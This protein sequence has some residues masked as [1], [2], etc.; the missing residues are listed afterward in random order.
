VDGYDFGVTGSTRG[1]A[2]ASAP[3]DLVVGG[4]T[5]LTRLGEGGMGVVHLARK[6]GGERVALKVLRPHI[7]GDDEA[8]ARLAREVSSLSRIRSKWVAEIVD[9]DPWGPIPFI[10]TR[11]VP[12]F[13]LHDLVQDEGPVTG[14]DLVWLAR[15]LAEGVASVHAAGVLHRDVKPSNVLMEGRTPI[16]IDF[17]LARV[18]DDPRLTHTG[19]LLGTPGYLPPEILYGEDATTATDV[20]SWAATV[21]YAGLGHAPY[22]TGPSMA[23]MDRVRR[24]DHDLTGLPTALRQVL[25]HSLDP[26]PTR[27]PTLE[28]IRDLLDPDPDPHAIWLAGPP[29]E[30]EDLF[31]MPLAIAAQAGIAPPPS[32]QLRPTL[33]EPEPGDTWVVSDPAQWPPAPAP[34]PW[35]APVPAY[36]DVF[37]LPPSEPPVSRA[38]RA[39]RAL[40]LLCGA[41]AAAAAVVV[42]PYLAS[43]VL[44][45]LTWVL[46]SGSLT[47]SA[48]GERQRSRGRARWYDVVVAPLSAPWHL[49]RALPG[50]LMLVFWAAGLAIAGALLGYAA[51]V[52]VETTLFVSGLL[53]T[54]ALYFGPGGSRVRR[55]LSRL[56]VPLSRTPQRWVVAVVILLAAALCLGLVADAGI[57]WTPATQAPR[58]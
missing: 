15:C 10:A 32:P 3:P 40:L 41:V 51:S 49:L 24:G 36:D 44:V 43:L 33:V 42:W 55:P 34:A 7:V 30:P 29:E 8:R 23:I 48:T 57:D 19:W 20:H 1:A 56:V 38:E 12:G 14:H 45:A 6:P 25:E 53:L 31:T 58:G 26:D 17:G 11:Y 16:L 9:A 5:L 37:A 47:A 13:S 2:G 27:R 21:A 4:Y 46:R 54:G 22:G 35:P 28:R 18:A 39:R 50:T 52:S